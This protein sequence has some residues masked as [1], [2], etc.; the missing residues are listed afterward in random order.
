MSPKTF[1]K[2]RRPERF[3]DS[4][5]VEDRPLDRSMLEYHLDTLTNRGQEGD[6][7]RFARLLAEREVCP[8]LLPHTGPTGGGDSKVD[9]ETFPVADGLALGWY[10]GQGR[11]AASERWAFAFSA[12]KD[13]RAKVQSD[14]AKVAATGRGYAKAFFVSNQFVPDKARAEVEDALR[15]KHGVDVRIL[16]RS[17]ILDRVYAGR[18]EQLAIDE[19][20]LQVSAR[21]QVRKGP[22]DARREQELAAVDGRVAE[23]ARGGGHGPALVESLLQAALLA[24]GLER[25]RSEVDGRFAAARVA[26]E[27]HGTSHQRVVVAY[28]EAFGAYWWYEDYATFA[29]RL[30]DLERLVEGSDNVYHLELATGLW[31]A[32]WTAVRSGHVDAAAARLSERAA[33]LTERLESVTRR[34]FQPSSALQAE[35]LLL[36]VRLLTA[37]PEGVDDVLVAL[38]GVVDRSAGLLGFPL[39]ALVESL[40]ELGAVLG[41]RP[42]F[43]DLYE[44]AV[45]VVGARQGEVTAARLLLKRGA[46]Q[47]DAGYPYQAIQLIGRVLARLHKHESRPD[48]VRA[49][50]L[51][52]GAYERVGLLWAARGSLLNAAAVAAGEFWTAEAV[53]PVQSACYDRLRWVELRL[54][55]VPH[56]L[57]WHEV[58][59]AVKGA[60]A[61]RGVDPDRLA[62]GDR[63]FDAITAMLLLRTDLWELKRVTRLPGTL[64]D[65]T[66]PWASLALR[67]ALGHDDVV[68]GDLSG[69]GEQPPDLY[70]FFA[71]LAAQPAAADLPAA[72]TFYATRTASLV[73]HVLGCTVAAEADATQ[74]CTELAESILAALEGLLATGLLGTAPIVARVPSLSIRV[75]RADFTA[76]PFEFELRDPDGHPHAEVRVADWRPHALPLTAQQTLRDKI[77]D[78]LASLVSHAFFVDEPGQTLLPLFRDERAMERALNFTGSVMTVANVL[79]NMPKHALGD[80]LTGEDR[81]YR[82]RRSGAWHDSVRSGADAG[83]SNVAAA[84]PGASA[85]GGGPS[86]VPEDGG[87]RP[88][89]GW[90][91]A[92]HT[93]IRMVSLVR[94]SLWDEAKWFAT[95]FVTV[96]DDAGIPWLA[97]VF[98]NGAAARTIFSQWRREVGEQDDAAQLRVSV[99]RGVSDAN[100][101]AYRIVIGT[102]P[103]NAFAKA[104]DCKFVVMM[105]RVNQ[106]DPTSSAN[107]DRFLASYARHGAYDLLPAVAPAA[108]EDVRP[109]TDLSIRK[110]ELV[111]IDAWQVGANDPEATAISEEN[112]PII[113]PG[114]EADAPV[115]EVLRKRRSS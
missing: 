50:Y 3:S 16:D 23:A 21:T 83:G 95:V 19:L 1:L 113:P 66:L 92:K 81:A 110:R 114:R 82:L 62:R 112:T 37:Q 107:L 67:F 97:P 61:E 30:D 100:P 94:P 40:G 29:A 44:A 6:F 101:H 10:V 28:Q 85:D 9:A 103:E 22:F 64:D 88:E 52:G 27:R 58:S 60:L 65:L 24:R 104:G 72:P 74:P 54:G 32:Q 7:E 39:L 99:V 49:L 75:R 33:W 34:D 96:E 55:R 12:K 46:Q 48:F 80:W 106:M 56:A 2:A 15:T 35:T 76:V 31:T 18:H 43:D 70:E 68:A 109:V 20:R 115:L 26:A 57:A 87:P 98:R 102:T 78:L 105:S 91:D 86:G 59:R 17:W 53:T 71:R 45:E 73:S 36:Q 108:I 51:L 111:V 77:T 11:Q 79:G 38:R 89:S 25:P 63:E 93:D 42:A 90:R 4:V 5:I 13:W 84:A 14:V 47:L 41:G 8:N 69:N